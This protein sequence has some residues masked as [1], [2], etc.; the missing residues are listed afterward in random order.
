MRDRVATYAERI[1]TISSPLDLVAPPA[2][3]AIPGAT[4]VVLSTVPRTDRTLASHG[5]VIFMRTATRII[6]AAL[7]RAGTGEARTPSEEPVSAP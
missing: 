2:S 7:S 4:N 3:C 6:L 5:G 1:T